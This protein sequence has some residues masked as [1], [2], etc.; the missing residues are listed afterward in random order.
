[1]N[2]ILSLLLALGL[3]TAVSAQNDSRVDAING[4][5]NNTVDIDQAGS[6]NTVG[7]ASVAESGVL[8]SYADKNDVDIDQIGIGNSATTKVGGGA[9]FAQS[10]LNTVKIHQ[11]SA[12]LGNSADVNLAN[13]T[14][15][16]DVDIRQNGE[17]NEARVGS[18]N[19]MLNEIEFDQDGTGSRAVTRI[20]AG[21]DRNDLQ[22]DQDGNDHEAVVEFKNDADR[23]GDGGTGPLDKFRIK[24]DGDRHM[25][26]VLI[27][28][29]DRNGVDIKQTGADHVIDANDNPFGTADGLVILGLKNYTEVDQSGFGGGSGHSYSQLIAGDSNV[30]NVTQ[31]D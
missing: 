25:A 20:V 12:S 15:K 18:F 3:T 30:L 11:T 9:P 4:S 29:G 13:D 2:H 8:L 16:T 7:T 28:G 1:M 23:N 17:S 14:D 6:A 22:V 21:S 5:S 31:S 27:D 26:T 19:S 24:Q 10:D